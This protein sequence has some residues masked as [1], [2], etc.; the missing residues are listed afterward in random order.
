MGPEFWLGFAAAGT[1]VSLELETLCSTQC[2]MGGGTDGL[3]S[4]ELRQRQIYC[5]L[6][7]HT[8]QG[9]EALPSVKVSIEGYKVSIQDVGLC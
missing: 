4:M 2:G 3:V 6:H 7:F 9:E 1:T 5:S 8:T